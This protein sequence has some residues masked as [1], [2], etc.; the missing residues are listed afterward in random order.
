M[1]KRNDDGG[2]RLWRNRPTWRTGNGQSQQSF[3]SSVD[4]RVTSNVV[5]LV[6]RRSSDC[7]HCGCY[8]YCNRNDDECHR[9][10]SRCLGGKGSVVFDGVVVV[11]VVV[12]MIVL[13]IVIVVIV[14]G[15]VV[16]V[17][18]YGGVV[19]LVGIDRPRFSRISPQ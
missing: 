2:E 8:W 18:V 11:V 5:A 19:I 12:V 14:V 15:I 16:V 7:C 17:V 10:L 6:R 9:H 13:V 3:G 4:T 1:R